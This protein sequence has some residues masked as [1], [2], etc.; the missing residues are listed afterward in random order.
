MVSEQFNYLITGD[1][2][3]AWRW[4]MDD[5]L[6]YGLLWVLFGF[7]LFVMVYEK[8]KSYGI[9]GTVLG[10][11]LM[12][13]SYATLAVPIEMQMYFLLLMGV[14]VFILLLKTIKGKE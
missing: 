3:G 1:V 14:M 8:T 10:L 4:F 2:I 6:G 9:G 7:L 11:Y 12:M 5:Y 13:V